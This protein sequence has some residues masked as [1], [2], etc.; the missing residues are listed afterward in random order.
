M[1]TFSSGRFKNRN[2]QSQSP[3]I[4]LDAKIS[5]SST[6]SSSIDFRFDR[7]LRCLKGLICST[8]F[9]R[10]RFRTSGHGTSRR[11]RRCERVRN[12]YARIG[13]ER[14]ESLVLSF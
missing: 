13:G 11:D 12:G 7:H 10:T 2:V 3:P 5:R 14:N 8:F 1:L 6:T 9:C 4:K